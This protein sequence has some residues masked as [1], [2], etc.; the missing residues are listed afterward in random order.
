MKESVH[1]ACKENAKK[2]EKRREDAGVRTY[3]AAK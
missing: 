2:Y 1:T 3:S